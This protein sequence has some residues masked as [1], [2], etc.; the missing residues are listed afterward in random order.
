[1]CGMTNKRT[2]SDNNDSHEYD[3]CESQGKTAVLT[4]YFHSDAKLVS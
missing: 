4:V 1:M 2:S 3:E